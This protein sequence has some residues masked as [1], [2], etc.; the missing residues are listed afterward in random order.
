MFQNVPA[1][2][3]ARS[4]NY[5]ES[6]WC[7]YGGSCHSSSA[8]VMIILHG[9]IIFSVSIH[10]PNFKAHIDL[11]VYHTFGPVFFASSPEA[12]YACGAC[13]PTLHIVHSPWYTLKCLHTEQLDISKFCKYLKSG[14]RFFKQLLTWKNGSGPG[15]QFRSGSAILVIDWMIH[16][17]FLLLILS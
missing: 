15:I 16:V 4:I 6:R 3:K 10:L 17:F 7:W 5:V 1:L 2:H 13:P 9:I 14:A 12:S 11:S 8:A